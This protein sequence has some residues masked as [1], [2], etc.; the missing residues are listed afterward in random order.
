MIGRFAETYVPLSVRALLIAESGANDG[1]ALP[2]LMLAIYLVR[3]ADPSNA[4]ST[5]GSAIGHW[6]GGHL[7]QRSG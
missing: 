7:A 4:W 5:L 2:Y 6:Y 1:L 3:R